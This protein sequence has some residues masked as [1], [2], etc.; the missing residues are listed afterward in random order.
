[1]QSSDLYYQHG[2]IF[3]GLQEKLFQTVVDAS[4][5]RNESVKLKPYLV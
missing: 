2:A 5:H 3:Y 1:M 4:I